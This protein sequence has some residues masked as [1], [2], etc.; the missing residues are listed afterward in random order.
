MAYGAGGDCSETFCD[1]QDHDGW[2]RVLYMLPR[3]L[4]YTT[5]GKKTSAAGAEPTRLNAETIRKRTYTSKAGLWDWLDKAPMEHSPLPITTRYG[6]G[7]KKSKRKAE[8][9]RQQEVS[10]MAE[11]QEEART[12]KFI[13]LARGGELSK[14]LPL[15]R[16][17]G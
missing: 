1:K 11:K 10:A 3:W 7:H 14:A 9:E 2:A 5:P 12:K 16:A 15:L 8:E 4:L 17:G 13:A 6:K